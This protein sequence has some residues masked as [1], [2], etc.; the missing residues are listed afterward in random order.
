MKLQNEMFTIVGGDDN[1]VKIK[2]NASHQIYQA[3]FPGN[4]ITPGVCIVQIICELLSGRLNRPL[5]LSKITNLKFNSTISPVEN[6]LVEVNF[7]T[8]D[9]SE[10]EYIAKGTITAKEAIMTKFSLV[11]IS[12]V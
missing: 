1:H 9:T 7:T 8:V 5:A 11:F 10:T 12:K 2:L 4:P 3:H 6:P